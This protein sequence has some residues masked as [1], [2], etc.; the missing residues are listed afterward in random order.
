MDVLPLSMAKRQSSTRA[1]SY[2]AVL[3]AGLKPDLERP[4]TLT[5]GNGEEIGFFASLSLTG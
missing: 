5:R 2:V 4:E 3:S 1:T